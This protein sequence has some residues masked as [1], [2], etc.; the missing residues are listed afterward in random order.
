LA[1][2]GL[3][4]Q[5]ILTATMVIQV[6]V[7]A[8]RQRVALLVVEFLT[9]A[10][11]VELPQVAAVVLNTLALG[12]PLVVLVP[13]VAVLPIHLL[14]TFP[15]TALAVAVVVRLLMVLMV[16]VILVLVVLAVL[17][18]I[19]IHLGLLLLEQ[20]LVVSTL[21]VVVAVEELILVLAV[22]VVVALVVH[23]QLQS[24]Q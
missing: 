23:H 17:A 3:A 11:M 1:L 18:I 13:L 20:V 2:A 10:I 21:A 8:H 19:L 9:S 12:Q 7:V 6:P 5:V 4:V 16:L 24:C 22:Q 14:L 15:N